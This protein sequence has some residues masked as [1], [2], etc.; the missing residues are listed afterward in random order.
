MLVSAGDDLA[1]SI[2]RLAHQRNITQIVVGKP[3]S[4][5]KYG[6]GLKKDDKAGRDAVNAA[7]EKAFSDGSWK[8]AFTKTVGPSGY[9]MPAAPPALEKY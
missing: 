7:I 6:V 5:E 8:A 1:G 9:P 2:L 4:T 3:F